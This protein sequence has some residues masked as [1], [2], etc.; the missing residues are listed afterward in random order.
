MLQRIQTLYLFLAFGCA[1]ALNFLPIFTVESNYL[2]ITESANFDA[3]GL[4][5]PG[6]SEGQFP[7]Y[8]FFMVLA[9]FTFAG[10]LLYKNRKKQLLVVRFSLILHLLTALGFLLF[11]LFGKSMIIE[12]LAKEGLEDVTVNFKLGFAY[13]LVFMALPFLLLAIRGI[14]ADEKLVKSLDRIR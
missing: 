1:I 12:A 5:V 14:R 2:G 6:T 13:Y 7:F 10:I 3:Y 4:N 11:A 9:L 8:I